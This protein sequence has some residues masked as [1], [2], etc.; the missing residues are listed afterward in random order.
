MTDYANFDPRAEP[1]TPRDALDAVFPGRARRRLS[2]LDELRQLEQ[3]SPRRWRTVSIG[4][5]PS[6]WLQITTE[7]DP[8]VI[9]VAPDEA[10]RGAG[11][12]LGGRND[13]RPV[14]TA[15]SSPA[16]KCG[17]AKRTGS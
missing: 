2:S 1:V 3:L 4:G 5:Q 14:P 8:L 9:E 17:P 15:V 13:S 11:E 10:V 6:D 12:L 16:S 7:R